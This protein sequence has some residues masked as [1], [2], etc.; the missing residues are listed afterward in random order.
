MLA[1]SQGLVRRR[2]VQVAIDLG[3]T[4]QGQRQ[5]APPVVEGFVFE[6]SLGE[7]G[8]PAPAVMNVGERLRLYDPAGH[9]LGVAEVDIEGKAAPRRL[10]ATEL[11][12]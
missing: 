7:H 11:A 5:G 6:E 1:R 9:F 8:Q 2:Q 10:L 3:T 4:L 12:D